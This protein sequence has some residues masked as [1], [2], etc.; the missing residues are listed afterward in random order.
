MKRHVSECIKER[1]SSR[2]Y[3]IKMVFHQDA[4]RER[5]RFSLSTER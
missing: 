4:R 1:K 5:A 2:H 3:V